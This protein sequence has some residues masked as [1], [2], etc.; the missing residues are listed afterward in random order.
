MIYRISWSLKP[1]WFGLRFYI[2]SNSLLKNQFL[3]FVT[4]VYVPEVIVSF[5]S[6]GK[7]CPILILLID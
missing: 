1:F 3:T 2:Y 7:T 6:K 5:I 4:V